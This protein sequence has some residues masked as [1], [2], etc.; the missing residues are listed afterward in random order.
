MNKEDRYKARL[1][2]LISA[3]EG[4]LPRP[5]KTTYTTLRQIVQWIPSN[6]HFGG[7]AGGGAG[8]GAAGQR[9]AKDF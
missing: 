5:A 9:Q 7:E 6:S 8:V 1:N 3:P 4:A 2:A